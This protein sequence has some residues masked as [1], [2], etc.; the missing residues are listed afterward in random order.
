VL[1][2]WDEKMEDDEEDEDEEEEEVANEEGS[3]ADPDRNPNPNPDPDQVA[4]KE[5][6][7]AEIEVLV[8]REGDESY[9]MVSRRLSNTHH[10]PL[11]YVL[12]MT[13]H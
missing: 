11:I 8:K 1:A 5:G 6:S 4:N 10:V 3:K 2:E 12:L 9:S 13:N 7:K